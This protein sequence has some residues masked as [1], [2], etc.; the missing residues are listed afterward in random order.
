MD[1]VPKE[2]GIAGSLAFKIGGILLVLGALI[3]AA[4]GIGS[5]IFRD[6][7]AALDQF[8]NDL[9][10]SLR[11]GS[12]MVEVA[13]ELGQGLSAILI[14]GSAEEL[15]E[16]AR[17]IGFAIETLRTK[18]GELAGEDID[19]LAADIEDVEA[20]VAEVKTARA[21]DIHYDEL[22]LSGSDRLTE[23]VGK[24][25][26]GLAQI[27]GETL[28]GML[29]DRGVDNPAIRRNDLERVAGATALERAVKQLQSVVLTGASADD[30]QGVANADLASAVLAGDIRGLSGEMRL[31]EAVFGAIERALGLAEGPESILGARRLVIEARRVAEDASHQAAEKAGAIAEAARDLGRGSVS[32]IG[33]ASSR[34]ASVAAGGQTAMLSIGVVSVIF[35]VITPIGA[36]YFVVR[37]L[38][39]VTRVTE[40]LAQGDMAP[41]EGF[42]RQGGEIGRMAAALGVFRDNMIERTRLQKEEREREAAALR[43][44]AENREREAKEARAREE[45]ERTR[46]MEAADAE[47]TRAARE[48]REREEMRAKTE[49]ERQA[50]AA[51]Q[52]RVVSEL[53]KGMKCLAAGD[54]DFRIERQFPEAYE[55][56]RQNFNA[57]VGTLAETIAQIAESAARIDRNS[58]EIASA[59]NDLS[60]RTEQQAAALEETA[61]AIE[62]LTTSVRNAAKNAETADEDVRSTR[63]SAEE[64]GKIVHQ[65]VEAMGEIEHSSEQITRIVGVID[66]IAF[67]TNL[68]ALNAG[69]EAARA[70]DAGRGFAVVASEVRALA[71]RSSEAAKEI[72]T[73]IATSTDQVGRGVE[74]VR[75]TGTSLGTIVDAVANVAGLVGG[76]AG[77][78]REQAQGLSE[79]NTS[80]NQLDK[81][82]QQNAAMVE[83]ATAASN[84]MKDE[85]RTLSGLFS[86]FKVS[87]LAGVD[88]SSVQRA[89]ASRAAPAAWRPASPGGKGWSGSAQSRG[90]AARAVN[91]S[92]EEDWD[93]F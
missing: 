68:L 87:A 34:L 54:L 21:D 65:A 15:D 49:A 83:E 27:S 44:E 25:T 3:V 61:A 91:A 89:S 47:R 33:A 1:M 55:P 60:H 62:E 9:V 93:E 92:Q 10:P 6:F 78:A 80:V 22:T 46:E 4:V 77:S 23:E 42:E 79:I 24:A 70:G 20:L 72:K 31:D 75:R 86:R 19:A 57:A 73:L 50:H 43:R 67:Q 38:T 26:R 76:I 82:T 14:A 66:D 28:S 39:S 69:V 85:A 53:A 7:S 5:V 71:Q 13:G 48:H 88:T 36:L 18:A 74:L 2:R 90:S 37:P 8:K 51:E 32:E 29:G 17:R 45:A 52:D 12:E 81:V 41:V 11:Q 30:P 58:G 35:L 59:S 84:E 64:G 56:L 40:R 16:S 63:S